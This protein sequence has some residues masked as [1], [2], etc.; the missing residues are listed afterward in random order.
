MTLLADI[1][2]AIV[3][4]LESVTDIGLVHDYQRYATNAAEMAALYQTTIGT[5]KQIRGWWVSRIATAEGSPALG[6][7]TVTHTW[8]I[9]GYMGLDDAAESEK[10]F[11]ELVELVRDT[12]RQDDNLGGV[13]DSTVL[14][15]GAGLQLD[16]QAPV[17]FAGVLCHAARLTLRTRHHEDPWMPPN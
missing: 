15:E 16:E 3:T 6:R 10:T 4:R 11:D 7:Y 12:F 2:A 14:D 13:V 8:R 9:H 1:R 17:V 5:T